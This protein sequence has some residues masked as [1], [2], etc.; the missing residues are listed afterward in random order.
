[1]ERGFSS[2]ELEEDAQVIIHALKKEDECLAWYVD[3][4]EE[5]KCK[6]RSHSHWRVSFT[7][8]EGNGVAHSSAKYGLTV[9]HEIL[10][11]NHEIPKFLFPVVT[12]NLP[13]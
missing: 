10:W 7:P 2:V 8:R 4:I 6:L 1:M 5:A 9:P 12:V 3:L 13:S 11:I